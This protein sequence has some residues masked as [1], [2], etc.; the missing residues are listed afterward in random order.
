MRFEGVPGAANI[1]LSLN[2]FSTAATQGDPIGTLTTPGGDAGDTFTYTLVAGAGDDDNGKFQISGDELQ[3]GAHDFSTAADGEMFSVR[4]RIHPA[5]RPERTV[6]EALVVTAFA[7]DL[8]A[9]AILT[10][11]PARR[12]GRCAAR[13]Q[14]SSDF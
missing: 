3:V 11:S 10:L 2:T 1:L 9:P 5:R 4:V 6:E 12:L 8:T 14:P 7:P 13:R